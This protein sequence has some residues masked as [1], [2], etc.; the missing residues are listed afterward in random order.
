M[1]KRVLLQMDLSLNTSPFYDQSI[2]GVPSYP[3]YTSCTR[4]HWHPQ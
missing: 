1:Q 4:S 2:K 3:C